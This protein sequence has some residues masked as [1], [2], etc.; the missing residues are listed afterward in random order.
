MNNYILNTEV[1]V[2]TEKYTNMQKSYYENETS[3]MKIQNHQ[4]HNNNPDYWSILLAPL[5][6]GDW[7]SKR[8][9]DF[10]CGCGRNVA[11]ILNKYD[12]LSADGCDIS[13]NNIAYCQEYVPSVTDKTNCT[14]YTVDGKSLNGIPSD[15]YDMVMSTIVLQHI[16]VYTIRYAIMTDIFR[17]LKSGGIFSF[18]MGFGPGHRSTADY[19]EDYV[20]ARGTNSAHDVRVL[21][22]QYVIDDLTKIGFTNIATQIRAPWSDGHNNWIFAQ[23]TKP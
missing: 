3:T 11:N 9:L 17:T 5:D 23:G 13:S 4:V 10:G 8:V 21:D 14:F 16:C 15:T 20:D 12:V 7:S 22:E 2:N 1:N 6:H 18:Q 19:Y